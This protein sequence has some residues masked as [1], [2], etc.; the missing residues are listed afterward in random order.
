MIHSDQL[1]L[2][3]LY[4]RR[5]AILNATSGC[6]FAPGNSFSETK[7]PEEAMLFREKRNALGEIET[8]NFNP[9]NLKD[10]STT[11][12]IHKRG[13]GYHVYYPATKLWLGKDRLTSHEQSEPFDV[14]T[15]AHR[16]A[17]IVWG[18]DRIEDMT[19]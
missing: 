2:I 15:N 4:P 18:F 10:L 19:N 7:E 13:D 16:H 17:Q 9:K 5:F 14:K 1:L 8:R 3:R 11:A 6:F 12:Q